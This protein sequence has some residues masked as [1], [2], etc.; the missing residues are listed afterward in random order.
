MALSNYIYLSKL[1]NIANLQTSFDY[2]VLEL[3]GNFKTLSVSNVKYISLF[4]EICMLLGAYYATGGF[5]KLSWKVSC[6]FI[7]MIGFYG[8]FSLP[9]VIYRF[10]VAINSYDSGISHRANAAWIIINNIKN[11]I[12]SII[13][14][15]PYIR[16]I[17]SYRKTKF[18]VI[19][20]TVLTYA[21]LFVLVEVVIVSLISFNVINNF[22]DNG[23]EVLYNKYVPETYYINNYTKIIIAM[24][25]VLLSIFVVRVRMSYVGFSPVKK[26]KLYN[27]NLVNKSLRMILH[28]YKNMFFA[29]RQLN[30]FLLLDEDINENS[31]KY[32]E[33][34]K[35]IAENTL[36]T[37]TK[38][39]QSFDKLE[40]NYENIKFSK[41][42]TKLFGM[43]T[44]DER[45]N[46]H[47]Q[48]C[49][50]KETIYIDELYI[51][52]LLYNVVINAIEATRFVENPNIQIRFFSEENWSLIEIEDNGCGLEKSEMKNIFKPFV[53]YKC[54]KN[55]WGVGLYYAHRIVSAFNGEIYI[56]SVKGKYTKFEV[57]LP[58]RKAKE[59]FIWIR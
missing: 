34:I 15:Y 58:K 19:R 35:S 51:T 4:G 32:S 9:D 22:I 17:L 44:Q 25:V 59:K 54:G 30:D 12:I 36:Y 37:I 31:K 29:I 8:Y 5:E 33:E 18:Y 57:Y 24:M 52:E 3:I 47:I 55:N 26:I 6:I 20:K 49:D 14:F 16:S 38:Q 45:K 21:A 48:Y 39:I 10:Y 2:K 42:I 43:L 23:I 50:E 56:K 11:L 41:I 27:S 46:V 1:S 40:F 13:A 28:T 53:S 7:C